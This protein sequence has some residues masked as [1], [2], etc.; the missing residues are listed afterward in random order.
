MW[1]ARHLS[2]EV[3]VNTLADTLGGAQ[4]KKFS[5]R[6]SNTLAELHPKTLGDTLGDVNAEEFIDVLADI[7]ANVKTE[8]L[9]D[10]LRVERWRPRHSAT[11]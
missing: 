7:L 3:D 8:R 5:T 1:D 10:T 9:G 6:I 11:Y 4:G 2:S